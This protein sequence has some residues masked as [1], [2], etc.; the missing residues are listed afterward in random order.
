MKV[1]W[2]SRSV[3]DLEDILEYISL[4]DPLVAAREIEKILNAVNRLEENPLTGRKGRV[5]NTRE[6]VIPDSPYIAAYRVKDIAVDILRIL[7]GARKWPK[8][9]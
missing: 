2:L 9:F 4:D 5:N 8:G 6:L 1:R 7:H 3:K